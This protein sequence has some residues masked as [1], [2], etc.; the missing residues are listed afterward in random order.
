MNASIGVR[1][2][3]VYI[4]LVP[5][6]PLKVTWFHEYVVDLL[7]SGEVPGSNV[8]TASTSVTINYSQ[9]YGAPSAEGESGSE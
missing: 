1:R 8:I 4:C 6:F 5:C 9:S 7:A 2:L 3:D